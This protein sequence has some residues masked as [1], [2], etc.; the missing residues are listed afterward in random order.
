MRYLLPTSNM[1]PNLF[2]ASD[3]AEAFASEVAGF[4]AAQDVENLAKLI[5]FFHLVTPGDKAAVDFQL[6]PSGRM[7]LRIEVDGTTGD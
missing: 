1:P 4:A 7:T 6:D 3:T 2:D 5:S